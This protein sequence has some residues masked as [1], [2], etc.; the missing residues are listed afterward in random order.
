MSA[1]GFDRMR[2]EQ[3]EKLLVPDDIAPDVLE[4]LRR[5]FV[6][7]R[8]HLAEIDP[9]FTA[10]LAVEDFTDVYYDTPQ[11]QLLERGSGV[12]HRSRVNLSNPDD[13]K[14]GRELMQIKVNEISANALERGEIKYSIEHLFRPAL[15]E[16]SH[17]MLGIV[18]ASH[19]EAFKTRLRELGLDPHA[20]RPIL[21][22][23][24]LR[25]RIYL[26]RR[27]RP[28]MS[29]SFDQVRVRLLG[30]EVSFCEIE[31]ELN[32]IAFTDADEPTRRAMESVLGRV[33]GE[34][35]ATFPTIRSDLTPKYGKSFHR[36]EERIP[37]LRWLV[38]AGLH[39]MRA[40][41]DVGLVAAGIAGIAGYGIWRDAMARR[42]SRRRAPAEGGTSPGIVPTPQGT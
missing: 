4:F 36:L 33:V 18:K 16:D 12:R 27:G 28:F 40:A 21:T 8:A 20:M 11:L 25:S 35:R 10:S 37:M 5:R 23:R 6:E 9:R 26:L 17:P 7:D 3:E 31:P 32:E 30:Q 2:I 42:E 24:D 22:V 41:V 13:V 19:R 34:I 15:P 39:T 1:A 14:S 38:R 29:V